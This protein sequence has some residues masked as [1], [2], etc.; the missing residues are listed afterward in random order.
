MRNVRTQPRNPP[1]ANPNLKGLLLR[2]DHAM[3]SDESTMRL[4]AILLSLAVLAG[5]YRNCE[6]DRHSQPNMKPGS[7][8]WNAASAEDISVRILAVLQKP[9]DQLSWANEREMLRLTLDEKRS[10]ATNGIK[11]ELQV[12]YTTGR[13]GGS[14]EVRVVIV[15]SGP[16]K[17][18]VRLPVPK[19]GS[20]IFVERAGE[21][22]PLPGNPPRSALTLEIFQ[23][24]KETTFFMNIPKEGVRS[25]GA[26]FWWD[27]N[28]K[29]HPL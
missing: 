17:A 14:K 4:T 2:N 23:E 10:I 8:E 19:F 27:E 29:W 18:D 5:C 13:G 7:P 21:L 24:R 11:G 26:I 3:T 20:A 25:G 1:P 16:L 9:A 22:Q 28:G 12:V 6:Q 15:Q